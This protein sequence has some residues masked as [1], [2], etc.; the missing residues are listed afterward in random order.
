MFS[1]GVIAGVDMEMAPLGPT[2]DDDD[3]TTVFE[4]RRSRRH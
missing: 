3:D 4:V 2:D 1:Y